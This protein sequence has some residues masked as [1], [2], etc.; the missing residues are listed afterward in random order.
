[1]GDA[2]LLETTNRTH[3]V[4]PVVIHWRGGV[5]TGVVVQP[6]DGGGLV[7]V[8]PGEQHSNDLGSPDGLDAVGVVRTAQAQDGRA[9]GW[10][11]ARRLLGP[12]PQRHKGERERDGPSEQPKECPWRGRHE[13]LLRKALLPL[14]AA[15]ASTDQTGCCSDY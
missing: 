7:L 9:R 14:V 4:V 2:V 15:R 8:R 10:L 3:L 1:H 6:E 5:F 11:L 13:L 12:G